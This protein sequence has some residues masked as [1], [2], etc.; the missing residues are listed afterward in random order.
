LGGATNNI[1]GTTARNRPIIIDEV[2]ARVQLSTNTNF[3]NWQLQCNLLWIDQ[4]Q[5]VAD[6]FDGTCALYFAS[7]YQN[8]GATA[9]GYRLSAVRPLS[10]LITDTQAIAGIWRPP[11]N[12]CILDPEQAVI[13]NVYDFLIPPAAHLWDVNGDAA[14]TVAAAGDLLIAAWIRFRQP[15]L[16]EPDKCL[17][18]DVDGMPVY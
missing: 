6:D 5:W 13:L 10:P 17:N 1:Y 18:E 7:N 3:Y 4:G 16:N 9:Q 11:K 12:S 8:V 15:V 14:T 2:G